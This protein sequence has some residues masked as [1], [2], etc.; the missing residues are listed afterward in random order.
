MLTAGIIAL[1]AVHRMSSLAISEDMCTVAGHDGQMKV[2]NFLADA[3]TAACS[4]PTTI[5]LLS[6]GE[7][8]NSTSDL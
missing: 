2:C 4:K 1:D 5:A 7:H 3:T 8:S 6:D